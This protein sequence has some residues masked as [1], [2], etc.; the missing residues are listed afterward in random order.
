MPRVYSPLG[1]NAYQMEERNDYRSRARVNNPYAQQDDI[2][3]PYVPSTTN[4]IGGGAQ[5]G[6]GGG[7]GDDLSSLNSE[8]RC[9]CRCR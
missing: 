5:M 1:R 2:S 4:L 8:V 7:G 9:C 6:G 3:E